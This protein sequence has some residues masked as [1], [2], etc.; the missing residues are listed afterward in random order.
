[1]RLLWDVILARRPGDGFMFAAL[2]IRTAGLPEVEAWPADNATLERLHP[3]AR[4]VNQSLQ[5]G[6]RIAVVSNEPIIDQVIADLGDL[7]AFGTPARAGE[8]PVGRRF[9]TI[10]AALHWCRRGDDD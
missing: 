8:P 2:D 10:E 3:V 6:F 7:V 1:M 9:E 5:P 4:M